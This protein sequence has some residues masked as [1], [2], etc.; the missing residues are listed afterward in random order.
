MIIAQKKLSVDWCKKNVGKIRSRCFK[1]FIRA[2]QVTN[3]NHGSVR[4]SPKQSNS[5]PCGFSKTS[6]IKRKFFVEKANRNKWWPVSSAK[7]VMW[8]L[9]HLSIV[10]R[11][12][13]SGTPQF[14]CLKSSNKFEK[15]TRNDESLLIMAMQ[16]LSHRLKSA[17][18]APYSPDWT[19]NDFFLF[20]QIRGK[21]RGQRFSSPEDAVEA[22]KS[23]VLKVS[24]SE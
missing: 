22:F 15:R 6:Q 2:S 24:Q 11:S 9:F 12:T 20:P 16:V 3:T 14:V 10:R 21:V 8:R 18:S 4:I 7:L 1:T 13:L 19:P 5:P 17:L 23:H